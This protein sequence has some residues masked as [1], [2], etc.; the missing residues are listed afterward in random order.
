MNS[1]SS[2]QVG[3]PLTLYC[4]AATVRG[5]ESEV[6]IVWTSNN[7]IIRKMSSINPTNMSTSQ[8]YTDSYT[9]SQLSTEDNG[10]VYQCQVII[11][12]ASIVTATSNIAL[13]VIG[14]YSYR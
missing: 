2:Q 10:K 13:D 8:I 3:K 6:D 7:T 12:S 5:I 9:I 14:K 11:N 1:L 4:H